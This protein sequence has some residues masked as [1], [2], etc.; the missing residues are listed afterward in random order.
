M[1]LIENL[2]NQI[3]AQNLGEISKIQ[4][5][6]LN[7]DRFE[8]ILQNGLKNISQM[9]ITQEIPKLGMP[10]GM[11]I[12]PFDG[13]DSMQVKNKSEQHSQN[14]N[15]KIEFKVPDN[16]TNFLSNSMKNFS[17]NNSNII[18]TLKKQA[19][20]AYNHF[21]KNLIENITEL[22]QDIV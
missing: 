6:D 10:A 14:F 16:T 8:K 2:I 12:E 9:N 5:F 11:I 19:I 21:G 18:N 22:A 15:N 7:D 17:E 1:S 13:T 20:N 4:N 3:S